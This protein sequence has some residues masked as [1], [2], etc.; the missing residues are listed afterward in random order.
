MFHLSRRNSIWLTIG[1]L[2]VFFIFF[3]A[4]L[5][6][7]NA[8]DQ[9]D[10]LD[11]PPTP[12]T[13]PEEPILSSS[14][15]NDSSNLNAISTP[16]S[17]SSQNNAY[18]TLERFHRTEIRDG[19]KLWEIEAQRGSYQPESGTAEVTDAIFSLYRD[20]HSFVLKAAKGTL[21]FNGTSLKIANLTGGVTL[22]TNG[23]T[24]T[25]KTS[26][27]VYD[28][29]ANTVTGQGEVAVTG[30]QYQIS[31]KGFLV[32]LADKA[33]TLEQDVNTVI[34]GSVPMKIEDG[35]R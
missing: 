4:E 17:A 11:Q 26:Q 18:F 27:A 34:Q 28:Q 8:L 2:V 15:N 6:K 14:I 21:A 16:S 22:V 19:K 24:V 32:K 31:G 1:I 10:Q 23:G 7:K 12:A 13:T 5:R 29:A 35:L 3:A 33:L 20:N 30:P 25:I 9:L